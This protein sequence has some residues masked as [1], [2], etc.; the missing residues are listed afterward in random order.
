M[1]EYF[2]NLKIGKKLTL[3]FSMIILLY[4]LTAAASL[5]CLRSVSARMVRL[6]REPFAN[7]QTSQ[8]L[9]ANLQSV[10]KY[11]V[12]LAS[13]EDMVDEEG[14]YKEILSMVEQE[15]AELTQLSNGYVSGAD[16][17]AELETEFE[18]LKA[19]RDK[20][21]RLWRA[22]DDKAAL[23]AYMEEYA[24]QSKVVRNILAEVVQLSVED[25]ENSLARAQQI[26]RG[27]MTVMAVASVLIIFSAVVLCIVLARSVTRPIDEV[28][29]AAGEIAEGRL[30]IQL[31]YTA[32]N[33]LGGLA[34]D[35]R[36]TAAALKAYL[37]ELRRGMT[38]LGTGHLNY[39]PEIEFK[40]DF[41]AMSASLEEIGHLLRESIRQIGSSAV[42]VS[43]GADQVSVGAQSL[44]QGASEQAGA[45]QELAA[46]INEIADGVQNNADNAVRSSQ[47][48]G[49]V[50]ES[51]I[52][53][54]GQMDEA[55]GSIREIRANSEE[56]NGI[57]AEMEEIAFRT[58]I[59]SLNASVEA[60]R[61][62]EAGRGFAVVAGEVRR[63][64]A[65]AAQS[66]KLTAQLVGKN[67]EAVASGIAAVDATA[68]TLSGSVEGARQVSEMMDRISALSLQQADA[69]DQIRRSV[70][71]IS[72]IVQGN[73]ATSEESAAASE[74]LS[75]QA[76]ILKEL[77]DKFEI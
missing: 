21:I 42:Q 57:V 61:A 75:A 45:V 55:L 38:A 50:G 65:Q 71:A 70:E 9:I 31:T 77:V 28:R 51:L 10:G 32:E 76:G 47:V 29:Q 60:A 53:C 35:I 20:V 64:A 17:V 41:V 44:A 23:E 8:Q 66:S 34:Q 69:I 6:Y 3:S 26:D 13:T 40:G 67:T 37:S 46:R 49:Q 63:L 2:K 68:Q 15:N 56:I 1:R 25:A 48:A 5:V 36:S 24:P 19:P 7:V 58:N 72:E 62:G 16:K 39:H 18:L 12:M 30:D 22:G 27:I 33:E 54:S 73:S 11:L 74:E 14:Y 4:G 59:L 43:G 52:A